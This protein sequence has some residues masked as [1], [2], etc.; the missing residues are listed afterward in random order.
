[1]TISTR[2]QYGASTLRMHNFSGP[3]TK[4]RSTTNRGGAAIRA[5]PNSIAKYSK[6]PRAAVPDS[7]YHNQNEDWPSV[8]YKRR[9]IQKSA[10]ITRKLLRHR[11][12]PRT[13]NSRAH[14]KTVFWS[15]VRPFNTSVHLFGTRNTR[16]RTPMKM[17]L[18]SHLLP[19]AC[20][21]KH[22]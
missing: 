19:S 5:A 11:K 3:G 2:P 6:L 14:L 4:P 10:G 7:G 8:S 21:S 16:Y 12:K 22:G 18:S 20:A 17:I 9:C 1:M 13:P 15:I